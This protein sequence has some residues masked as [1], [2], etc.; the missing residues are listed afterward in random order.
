MHVR[1]PYRGF[2]FQE[3]DDIFVRR[4]VTRQFDVEPNG[5]IAMI[6]FVIFDESFGDQGIQQF[7]GVLRPHPD[8]KFGDLDVFSADGE[9]STRRERRVVPPFDGSLESAVPWGHGHEIFA[10]NQSSNVG[11]DVRRVVTW[12]RRAPPGPDAFGSVDQD[13]RDDR[14]VPSRFDR[15]PIVIEVLENRI[16]FGMEISSRFG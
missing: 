15:H 3:F 9:Q 14:D 6:F 7:F 2:Q 13:R 12:D 16:V 5:R 8:R 11:R 4:D 10:A 1:R